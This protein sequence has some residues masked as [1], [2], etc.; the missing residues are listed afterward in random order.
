MPRALAVALLLVLGLLAGCAAGGGSGGGRSDGSSGASPRAVAVHDPPARAVQKLL[1]VIEE[2]HSLSQM[3]SG[4]PYTFSLAQHY[5]YATDYHALRHPSLPNYLAIAG[6][7][8]FGV[9]DD[10]PPSAHPVSAPSVFGQALA[11]GRT[12]GAYADSMPS[13]CAQQDSGTYAVR[14]NPWTYFTREHSDC[15]AHDQPMD[16]FAPDV[17]AGRL[18]RVGMVT[19]DKCHDAHDCPLSTADAWFQRLMTT[20]RSGPDWRSGHLAVVL[21]ADEDDHDTPGNVVLTTVIHPS[22]SH[23]VVGTPLTHYSLT[24]LYDE[25]AGLPPL[26]EAAGAPSMAKAFGLPLS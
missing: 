20:I 6:G 19:P 4:M 18:P 7:H 25:V 9:Q 15:V 11:A 17:A 22:Q 1:V 21:T 8:M 14:H 10:A 2:N 3:R 24:R 13:P 23:H 12:A 16:A 5:G 26:G